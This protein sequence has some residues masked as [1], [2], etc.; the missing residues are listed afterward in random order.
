MNI[1]VQLTS[2]GLGKNESTV[3]LVLLELGLTQAGE[4]IKKAKLHRMLV[5]NA[6][7]ELV[8]KG[9]VTVHQKKRI[10][11]FQAGDPDIF[12]EKINQLHDTAHELVPLLRQLQLSGDTAVEVRTL[13]GHEGFITNLQEVVESVARCKS[14]QISIIGGASD[15]DFYTAIG[16]WYEA[17]RNLLKQ[18]DI[19]KRLVAPASY[20]REFK[21][22][23]AKE[24]KTELK[25]IPQ[26]LSSPIYTR[27]TEGMV[28]IEIYQPSLTIIQIKNS[29]VAQGYLDSFELLWKLAK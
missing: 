5:Y 29:A 23:F 15:T 8:D 16:G 19:K 10:K 9:Y 25:V 17:Y 20:S 12:L 1:K 21:E 14:K 18:K 24:G 3:Y 28:S 4:I 6:L 2:L 7:N 22:K 27:I 11:L 13:V 26:G